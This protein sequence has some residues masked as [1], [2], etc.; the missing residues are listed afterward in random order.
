MIVSQTYQMGSRSRERSPAP[1]APGATFAKTAPAIGPK[2][3]MKNRARTIADGADRHDVPLKPIWCKLSP[4]P[5]F[6]M[7]ATQLRSRQNAQRPDRLD[8]KV[9]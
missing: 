8:L 5:N 2:M 6:A 7:A 3:N 4:S 1:N 9:N